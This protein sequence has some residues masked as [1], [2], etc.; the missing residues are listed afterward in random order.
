MA[1]R[2]VAVDMLISRPLLI[3]DSLEGRPLFQRAVAEPVK[4]QAQGP[5]AQPFRVMW[6]EQAAAEAGSKLQVATVVLL[7]VAGARG[8][9]A[10]LIRWAA[11]VAMATLAFIIGDV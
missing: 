6:Q 8:Q 11:M 4:Q 5:Q 3:Q 2:V 7:P 10:F 9:M 1:V